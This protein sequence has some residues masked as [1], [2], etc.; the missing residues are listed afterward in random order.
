MV[1]G[2]LSMLTGVKAK[3][4][5]MDGN[6]L[7]VSGQVGDALIGGIS[8]NADLLAFGIDRDRLRLL[9]RRLRKVRSWGGDFANI[10]FSPE[11]QAII[12]K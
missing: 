11:I 10:E 12:G 8:D 1:H 2:G 7:Q 9:Q 3:P 6:M 5:V 4:E